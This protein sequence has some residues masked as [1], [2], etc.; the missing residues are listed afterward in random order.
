MFLIYYHHYMKF[1]T[2]LLIFLNFEQ[3]LMFFKFQ[4][5]D[6]SFNLA[7]MIYV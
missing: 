2:K 1:I 7:Q 4:I 6:N 3:L 5:L